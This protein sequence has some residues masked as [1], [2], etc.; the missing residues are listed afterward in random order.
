M[1]LTLKRSPSKKN[2]LINKKPDNKRPNTVKNNNLTYK[3]DVMTSKDAYIINNQKKVSNRETNTSSKKANIVKNEY[4]Y[5][6]PEPEKPKSIKKEIEKLD[7]KTRKHLKNNLIKSRGERFSDLYDEDIIDY[8]GLSKT[9]APY[10][11]YGEALLDLDLN[12]TSLSTNLNGARYLKNGKLKKYTK[13]FGKYKPT[14]LIELKLSYD[15]NQENN[16]ENLTNSKQDD[17]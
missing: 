14:D 16:N 13:G 11:S 10:N 4:N 17:C 12:N 5:K 9:F 7:S 15:S 8:H 3:P 6:P 2:A 1:T